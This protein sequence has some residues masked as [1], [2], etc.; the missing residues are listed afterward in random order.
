MKIE[1]GGNL[2][3]AIKAYGG[4]RS[5]WLDISTGISPFSPP[6]PKLSIDDWQ[7]LPEQSSME[8]L[9]DVAKRYYGSVQNCAVT[10]GSQFLINHLPDLLEGEV[11]IVEPTYGE[12][13]AS[14][15]RHK[16][17][18]NSIN[19]LDD[20][21]NAQS[22]ILA[23]PN[24]PTGQLFSRDVL[25]E[26]PTILAQRGGYL[27]VD[28]AFCDVC[29]QS[30]MLIGDLIE[31]LIVLK[32]LGKF[33]GLAGARIGFVFAHDK[34]LHQLE[35]LQGP[36]AVSGPSLAV[37]RDILS[38]D[39]IRDDLLLKIT[40]RHN[41]MV[42]VLKEIGLEVVGGTKLFT[43]IRDENAWALHEH[44]LTCKILTRKFDYNSH[45]LRLGLTRNQEEDHRLKEA[46]LS[47]GDQ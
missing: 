33:F 11:G 18:F 32:S 34:I 21:G 2:E 4:L 13:A 38:S 15:A 17:D 41:E 29:E 26:L 45:W 10:S 42:T 1:H 24:N 12:Y 27:V 31:N 23:N 37:A 6:I 40:N 9:A 28:E 20:I 44:L 39:R 35:Q 47:F 5:E 19:S 22:I 14:F 25:S 36:W 16:R 46:I 7:R 43:L 8:E 30:S 3:K